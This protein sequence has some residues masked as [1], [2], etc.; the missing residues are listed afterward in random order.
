[1]L[2][3]SGHW[4]GVSHHACT[5]FPHPKRPS[6]KHCLTITTI[7]SQCREIDIFTHTW[8]HNIK[9]DKISPPKTRKFHNLSFNVGFE[10]HDMMDYMTDKSKNCTSIGWLCLNY[11][12]TF[13]MSL[14]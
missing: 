9:Y 3:S 7:P 12:A 6:K 10:S 2:K 4:A 11:L 13:A 14:N 8:T 1:M 5:S